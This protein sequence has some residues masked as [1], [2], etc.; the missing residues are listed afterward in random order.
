MSSPHSNFDKYEPLRAYLA[1]LPKQ[2]Y[3]V[4]LTFKEIEAVIGSDLPAA[5]Y[6]TFT[7]WWTTNTDIVEAPQSR[8]W[9]NAGF[10]VAF[11]GYKTPSSGCVEFVRG[12]HRW[13]GIAVDSWKFGKLPVDERLRQ[14]ALGYLESGKKLCIL[15]GEEPAELTWPRGAVV[16][17]C[18]RHAIELFLKSCILHR[19]SE[20]EKCSH[21]ISKL[22]QQYFELY[23][24][25]EFYFQT[26]YDISME[27]VEELL[28]GRMEVEDFER[29]HDQVY[30]YLSDK[31]GRSPKS[32]HVFAPGCWLSMIEHLEDNIVRIWDI[33]RAMDTGTEKGAVPD[34]T[35]E[36]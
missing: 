26:P 1:A 3:T 22:R 29:K 18:Y 21:D 11:V 17:F 28:G 25:Q 36:R 14:L 33:I 23:P 6:Q 20:I 16:C 32:G 27:D 15:L 5:A 13:P 30:R 4:E 9:L 31:Q 12:L 10:G 19:V 24:S 2:Q 35:G 34:E 8:A 7:G